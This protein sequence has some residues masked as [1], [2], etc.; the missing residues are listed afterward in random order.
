MNKLELT[1][2]IIGLVAAIITLLSSMPQKTDKKQKEDNPGIKIKQVNKEIHNSH[3]TNVVNILENNT[4]SKTEIINNENKQFKINVYRSGM[5]VVLGVI[6][7]LK[8]IINYNNFT[9]ELTKSIFDIMPNIMNLFS[10]TLLNVN[11]WIIIFNI[12]LLII[13]LI[14]HINEKKNIIN[15]FITTFLLAM[16]FV[17]LLILTDHIVNS[18]NFK[19]NNF[20]NFVCILLIL[21]QPIINMAMMFKYY[22]TII[23]GDKQSDLNKEKFQESFIKIGYIIA[24][25]LFNL[26]ASI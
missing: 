16:Q 6:F 23:I 19:S 3:V 20:L 17:I 13:L 5:V 22:Q 15:Y 4:F 11:Q 18:L 14:R 10:I 9:T 1:T 24:L 26:Y 25:I 7:I 2:Q 8:F 12:V 21:T